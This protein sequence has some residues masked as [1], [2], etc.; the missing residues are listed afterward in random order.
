MKVDACTMGVVMA[1]YSLYRVS[2]ACTALVD[3]PYLELC[4]ILAEAI[5]LVLGHAPK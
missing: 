2:P 3:M 4:F 1:E 5:L